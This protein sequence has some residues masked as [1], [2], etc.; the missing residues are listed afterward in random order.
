MT[1][2]GPVELGCIPLCMETLLAGAGVLSKFYRHAIIA[3]LYFS[4][5]FSVWREDWQPGAGSWPLTGQ[6]CCLSSAG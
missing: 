2:K 3:C 6:C 5:Y 4:V 1:G